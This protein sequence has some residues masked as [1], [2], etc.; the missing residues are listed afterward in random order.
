MSRG[1]GYRRGHAHVGEKRSTKGVLLMLEADITLS[2]V[3][4]LRRSAKSSKKAKERF[5]TMRFSWGVQRALCCKRCR[6]PY[7]ARGTWNGRI[8]DSFSIVSTALIPV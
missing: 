2:A 7:V 4:T 3:S 8:I 1:R 5:G 6:E